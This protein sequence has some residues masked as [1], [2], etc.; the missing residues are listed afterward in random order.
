[1][2]RSTR[3]SLLLAGAIAVLP[4]TGAF[5]Q[6]PSAAATPSVS[7]PAQGTAPDAGTGTHKDKAEKKAALAAL[8]PD[9]RKEFKT[10]HDKAKSDPAVQSVDKSDKKAYHKA[11]REAMIKADP[12]VEA[13]LA[14]MHGG[15]THKKDLQ[16]S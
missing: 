2:K 9:E 3:F 13:I 11:M 1:M 4:V 6:D 8:T 5:A 7:T 14:K 12:N 10:A 16:T 15:K